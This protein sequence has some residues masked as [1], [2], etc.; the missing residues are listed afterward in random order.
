MPLLF[1]GGILSFEG[2]DFP[3]LRGA[4]REAYQIPEFRIVVQ[5]IKVGIPRCPV[6]IA[7]AGGDCFF[8]CFERFRFS[9]QHSAST[10]RA[11][12]QGH[13]GEFKK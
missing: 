3:G 8:Q 11:R 2:N 6:Q 13:T 10:R 4:F 1:S 7:V 9:Q 12:A 5:A